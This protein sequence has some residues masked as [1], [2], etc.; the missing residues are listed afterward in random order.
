MPPSFPFGGMENP[1][2]TFI[3]PTVIAGDKSLVDVVAH[4]ISHSWTGNL[5]TNFDFENFWLNGK[6]TC[7]SIDWNLIKL[8]CID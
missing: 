8:F 5:V 3:T 2:I 4:E 7:L 6:C 1:C